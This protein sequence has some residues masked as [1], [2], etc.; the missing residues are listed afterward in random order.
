VR[1]LQVL[2]TFGELGVK[3]LVAPQSSLAAVLQSY[4]DPCA[5][6]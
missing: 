2:A 1:R 6:R 5:G 4:Q 3:R